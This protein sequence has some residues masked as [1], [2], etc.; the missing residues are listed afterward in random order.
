[1]Y[2]DCWYVDFNVVFIFEC[3]ILGFYYIEVISLG[4]G[5]WCGV[6]DNVGGFVFFLC[7]D[8]VGGVVYIFVGGCIVKEIVVIIV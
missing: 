4:G 6:K 5:S 8:F 7:M 2:F 1:M 3:F